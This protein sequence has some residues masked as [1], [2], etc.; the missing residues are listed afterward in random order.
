MYNSISYQLLR[1]YHE[2]GTVLLNSKTYYPISSTNQLT[3]VG[4]IVFFLKKC[5]TQLLNGR[6]CLFEPIRSVLQSFVLNHYE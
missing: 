5:V 3:K 4:S 1:I 6:V 2:P